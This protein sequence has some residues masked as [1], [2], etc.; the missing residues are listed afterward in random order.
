MKVFVGFG[1]NDN[2]NW[3]SEIIIPFIEEL[4]CE[5]STGEDMQ[6]EQ[7]SVG[8]KDRISNSDACIGFLTRRG[9]VDANGH[10]STHRW[11]IEEL[12]LALGLDKAVF[13]IRENGVNT[14]NGILGHLQRLDFDDR[15]KVMLEIAKFISKEKSKLTHKA[16]I[17]LPS[18]FTDEIKPHLNSRDTKCLYRFL[19]KGK[20]YEEEETK[21]EKLRQRELGIIVR[22]IPSE[23][24]QIDIKITGPNGITWSS[25]FFSIGL[26][27]VQLQKEN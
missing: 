10:Y 11:V 20:F 21:L 14:Q 17:L 13:E 26:M 15:T 12:T 1:Y 8:V 2:D 18:D 22:K 23:E 5:V 19:Y 27:D 16:F 7:L 24:A 25:G 3:I 4:G 6:G 9:P